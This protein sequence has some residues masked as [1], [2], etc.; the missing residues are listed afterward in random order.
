MEG[1]RTFL[2]PVLRPVERGIYRVAG[3]DETEEQGWRAYAVSVLLMALVAIVVGYLTLRLQDV[4]PLNPTGA[5]AQSP[6]LAFNTS[7]SFETNTNW[8]N[9]SGETGVELLQPDDPARGPQLHVGC[10][11]PG[12]RDRPGPRSHPAHVADDRQLLGG[13]DPRAS[14]TSSCRSASSAPSS[15]SGRASRRPWTDPPP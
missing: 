11:R 2:S 8:Q 9:Y 12:R 6:E 3:I 15:S 14:C 5:A 13:P 7:V 4:L 1:E 10:D